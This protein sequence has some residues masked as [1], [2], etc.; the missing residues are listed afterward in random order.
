MT[1]FEVLEHT[2]DMG[3]RVRGATTDELFA[4]AAAALAAIVMDTAGAEAHERH[5]ISIEGDT[6]EERFIH[7]LN[8]V[9]W[10]M[11]G[12]SIAPA[13]F[14]PAAL[15]GEPRDEAKH[16]PRLVVKAVTFHQLKVW[17]DASGWTAEVYLDV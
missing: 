8:E 4:N 6:L 14:E 1:G 5:P 9:L 17:Q 10:L 11:D 15:W 12:R 3:F 16:P 13:R 7:W 2:A